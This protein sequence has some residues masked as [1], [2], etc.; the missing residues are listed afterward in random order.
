[1]IKNN[2][3]AIRNDKW[4]N[5]VESDSELTNTE[6]KENN[7]ENASL[8][9]P[10][11]A[12]VSK[13]SSISQN[14]ES[15][16]DVISDNEFE[17]DLEDYRDYLGEDIYIGSD[18]IEGLNKE[19]ANAQSWYGQ[20]A[21]MLGQAVVGEIVGG[22]IEGLGY[23]L[24]IPAY[25][26]IAKGEEKEWGNIVSDL[27]KDLREGSKDLMP[28]YEVN[29]GSND[30][31]DTAYWFSNGVS[32]A[33]TFSMMIPS[34]GAMKAL[35]FLG[36]AASKSARILN[37]SLD[38]A[39]NM[40]KKSKWMTEGVSQAIISRHIEN[41][42]EAA[43]TMESALQDYS[44]KINPKTG[45]FFTDEE[46]TQLAADAAASNYKFGWAM[47]LQDIPQYLALGKVFNP[48]TMRM[49][50]ALKKA[51][52]TGKTAKLGKYGDVAKGAGATFASEGFEEAYQYYIAER[53]KTLS[54][55]NAGLITKN[56]YDK[57]MS[58]KIG[59]AEMLSSAF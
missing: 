38:V 39:S 4:S 14:G 35:S 26:N 55:L 37:K 16:S 2:E 40:G 33:S 56:E 21:N 9:I 58:G 53:G 23:L 42:M 50:S 34:M 17:V 1:M 31:S 28:I 47:L 12:P 30:L 15:L 43:G 46:A 52:S 44:G 3:S 19:R 45:D 36:K 5:I 51:A 41:T 22:T 24:D 8:S 59:D 18:G 25:M 32:V 54:D 13:W 57:I 10:D 7:T 6:S 20:A 29:P 48:R 49:E 27:G 11:K